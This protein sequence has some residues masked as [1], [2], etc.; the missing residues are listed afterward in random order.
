MMFTDVARRLREFIEALDRRA[1]RAERSA[2]AA[3]ARDSAVLRTQ[4]VTRLAEIEHDHGFSIP[5]RWTTGS[6]T[7]FPATPADVAVLA[8]REFTL[9]LDQLDEK[10]A[11]S[12]DRVCGMFVDDANRALVWWIRFGALKAWGTKPDA[13]SRLRADALTLQDAC[14]IAAGFPL[15]QQWE[16]EADDFDSALAA[17]SARRSHVRS[18]LG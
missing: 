7:T 14:E 1:P 17:A 4:A 11:P 16:F 6:P 3:I 2:E 12:L 5:P 15:N 10:C 18:P 9:D 13:A 8:S